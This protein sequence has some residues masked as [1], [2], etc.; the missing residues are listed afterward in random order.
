MYGGLAEERALHDK[1][2]G[3]R[4]HREWFVKTDHIS[5]FVSSNSIKSVGV[6]DG[7]FTDFITPEEVEPDT[8][9]PLAI[10]RKSR[11]LSQCE[12]ASEVGVSRWM[13]NRIERG[14][15]NPSLKLAIRVQEIT[16]GLVTAKDFAGREVRQ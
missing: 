9:H 15:R 5:D 10:W 1:F 2:S 11:K 7:D 4:E 14:E 16:G 13:V 8:R 12:L 6:E 3:S